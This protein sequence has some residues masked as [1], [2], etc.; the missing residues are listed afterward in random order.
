MEYTLFP[1]LSNTTYCWYYFRYL[2]ISLATHFFFRSLF[3]TNCI[4]CYSN[5][6]LLSDRKSSFIF[7]SINININ[8]ITHCSL[9]LYSKKN[10][11]YLPSSLFHI[12]FCNYSKQF[13]YCCCNFDF[14]LSNHRFF[15]D[16]G[17]VNKFSF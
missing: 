3:S 7:I 9:D 15:H 1:H 8:P 2:E 13:V 5:F 6:Y 11:L 16:F 10:H 12:P 14:V 17:A 4:N